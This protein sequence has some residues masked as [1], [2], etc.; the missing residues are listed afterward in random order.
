MGWDD[1]SPAATT[2]SRNSACWLSERNH[3]RAFIGV[4]IMI[5]VLTICEEHDSTR[6]IAILLSGR[7][8]KSA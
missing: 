5:A 2:L 3:D 6:W 7:D 1:H 4:P 8:R